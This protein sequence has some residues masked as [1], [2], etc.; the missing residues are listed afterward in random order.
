MA[1]GSDWRTLLFFPIGVYVLLAVGLNVVV[2]QAG[3]L[4]LGYVAFFAIGAYAMALLGSHHWNF[5]LILPAGILLAAT[6][7]V[8]LGAPTLRLRGDYLAIVTLGFGEII[9][10][11][12]NNVAFTGGPRGIS[13]IPHPPSVHGV[14]PLTFGVLDTRP[15]YYLTLAAI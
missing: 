1:P 15:Y 11:T 9:R 7:G 12:A 3:L 8:V 2:G 14:Q 10:I 4:D 13:G 5:W 6:A